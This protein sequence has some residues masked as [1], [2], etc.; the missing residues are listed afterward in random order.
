MIPIDKVKQIVDTYNDLEKELASGKIDKKDFVKKSKISGSFN[1]KAS[2]RTQ[3]VTKIEE[4]KD[5]SENIADNVENLTEIW[6]FTSQVTERFCFCII[7][8]L[9]I[10]VTIWAFIVPH[11]NYYFPFP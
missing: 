9:I 7:L 5:N 3:M 1:A 11:V 6:E 4:E 8:Y 10:I 2:L